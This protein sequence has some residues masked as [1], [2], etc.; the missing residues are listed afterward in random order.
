MGFRVDSG[1]ADQSSQQRMKVKSDKNDPGR[2]RRE[3]GPLCVLPGP[4]PALLPVD[5]VFPKGTSNCQQ[6]WVGPATVHRSV[7]LDKVPSHTEWA[8]SFFLLL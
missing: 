7:C 5:A 2:G 1:T 3:R 4:L 8:T 6:P